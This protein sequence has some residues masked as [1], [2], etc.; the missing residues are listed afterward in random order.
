M[1]F[2]VP[3]LR[4]RRI[5][6]RLAYSPLALLLARTKVG[7]RMV[8]WRKPGFAVLLE[9]ARPTTSRPIALAHRY[10]QGTC[11]TQSSWSFDQ[12]RRPR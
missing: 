11:C 9:R 1:A 2:Q 8:P 5:P 10:N 7:L 3:L 6:S 12:R 4:R